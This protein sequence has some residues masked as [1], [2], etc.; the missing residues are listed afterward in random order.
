MSEKNITLEDIADWAGQASSDFMMLEPKDLPGMAKFSKE[1]AEKAKACANADNPPQIQETGNALH[2]AADTLKAFILGDNK[3]Q[4][5]VME[6]IGAALELAS[7]PNQ[8]HTPESTPQAENTT[9]GSATKPERPAWVDDTIVQAYIEQQL[10]VLPEMEQNILA[11]ENSHDSNH[12]A[13][14][15]RTLHTLKGESGVIGALEIEKVCHRIE[16]YLS[17]K[18][19]DIATDTLLFAIDWITSAVKELRNGTAS[20]PPSDA[21]LQLLEECTPEPEEPEQSPTGNIDSEDAPAQSDGTQPEAVPIADPDLAVD[22]IAEAQEHFDSSDHHLMILEK[23]PTNKDSIAA[24][25]RA[26]HTIKGV[27]GFIGLTPVCD[28]AHVAETLLDAIRKNRQTF[29][30]ATVDAIFGA[31]DHLKLMVSDLQEAISA[32]EPFPVRAELTQAIKQVQNILD[33]KPP[34][35]AKDQVSSQANSSS[36]PMPQPSTAPAPMPSKTEPAQVMK[37]DAARID[38]LLDTIG[39]L[40]IAEAIVA[41]DPDIQA[42]QSMRV[43]KR[44]ALLNKITRSLQD[45]AMS[46]RL[47]PVD[48]V[49]RKMARL[50]RDLCHKSN[51]QVELSIEGGDTE[52]D[53]SMVDRLGDPLVHMV[54][55]AVDHGIEDPEERKTC[56]KSQSGHLTLRAY[57]KGGSVRIEIQDDGKGL[58]RDAIVKKAIERKIITSG[59]GMPDDEVFGLIFESGFSTAAK[60]T[61]ISGRGVG[62]D[63]VRREIESLRGSISI[64]S[65]LGQGSVFTLALPLTTAIIDGMLI[66]ISNEIFILPT[67]SVLESIRPAAG[68]VKTVIGKGEVVTFRGELIPVYRLS[69]ILQI[70]NGI[71]DPGNAILIIVE[72]SNKKWAFM[73]DD[74]LGQQQVVIKSIGSAIGSIPGISGASILADGR[75]G[76]ILDV[77]ELVRHAEQI[78]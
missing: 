54:R 11:L 59:D 7:N 23:E 57:H 37:V 39:E 69:D 30:G 15:K 52:I 2:N 17:A 33:N 5:A 53:K 77:G 61:E 8:S 51:K 73:A 76:L 78:A 9:P 43:E 28:L 26:F 31:L 16:D 18:G 14:L 35:T 48:P 10:A 60:I 71:T 64:R 65:E 45:M 70:E 72:E 3:D 46:M 4:A 62:M 55:N 74:L 6:C 75:P 36:S 1:L 27:A 67:L 66:R 24:V 38:L 44:I 13:D 58:N 49:F 20:S 21:V 40:V 29:S 63:V 56:G 19:E 34:A 22:F 32:G 25:F 42:L 41:G 12:V 68:Q 47:V 50:V